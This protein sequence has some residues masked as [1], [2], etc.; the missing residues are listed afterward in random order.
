MLK[1]SL[2]LSRRDPAQAHQKQITHLPSSTDFDFRSS[3]FGSQLGLELESTGL[4]FETLRHQ[5]PREVSW[6]FTGFHGTV[7]TKGTSGCVTFRE[8]DW[9]VNSG[10]SKL[11]LILLSSLT[12]LLPTTSLFN[13]RAQCRTPRICRRSLANRRPFR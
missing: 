13:R 8:R 9:C 12:V 7:W 4:S 11:K 3:G 10:V 2:S 1:I 6:F 5:D